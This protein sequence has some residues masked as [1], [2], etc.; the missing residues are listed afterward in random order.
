MNAVAV[1]LASGSGQRFGATSVPKHL[2]QIFGI[3]I[4]VWTL[5]TAIHSKLFSSITVVTRKDDI[6]QTEKILKEYF[7]NNMFTIR[8]LEGSNVRIQ[9]FLL[10][11]DDLINANLIN[12]DTIVALFDANRP[13]TP[14]SQLKGL[15]KAALEFECSCPARPVVNG[16]ARIASDNIIEIPDKTNYVE[17]VTPEFITYKTLVKS[18]ERNMD[19]L[20]CFVEYALALGA[21]PKII[22]ASPLNIKLTFP[23]DRVHMEEIAYKYKLAKPIKF[24][25]HI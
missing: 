21:N 15:Y 8:I 18:L 2:T 22:E 6:C 13:F 11:L 5:D 9:S 16:V 1:V 12:E 24:K 17:F 20:N 10:G 25:P 7:P 23:D 4:L 19:R 14:L 3:P